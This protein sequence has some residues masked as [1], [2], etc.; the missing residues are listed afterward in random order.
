MLSMFGFHRQFTIL[1]L[2]CIECKLFFLLLMNFGP[3]KKVGTGN[4]E[5]ELVH[6]GNFS[7]IWFHLSG[8]NSGCF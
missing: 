2:S 3:T 4:Q 8:S 7:L 1:Q 5:D 6:L